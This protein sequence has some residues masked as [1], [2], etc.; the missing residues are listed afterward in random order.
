MPLVEIGAQSAVVEWE[1]PRTSWGD[2]NLEGVW[3]SDN[4]YAVPLE[5][6]PEFADKE[7][8]DG[9]DLEAALAQRAQRIEAVT[10][11][12]AG[13]GAGPGRWCKN[14]QGGSRRS[15]ALIDPR[16]GRLPPLTAAARERIA[17][18]QSARA[19]RGSA[20][21]YTDRSLWDRCVTVGL[22][23]MMFPTGYNNSVKILQTPGYVTITHEMIHGTRIIPLDG[24]PHL[25]ARNLGLASIPKAARFEEVPRR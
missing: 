11:G 25:P 14:L 13:V 5:R 1:R 9:P 3:S 19:A 18:Q 8:P 4:N 10:G 20:D 24:S 21:S 22:P 2:P 16:D 15:S 7:F 6:P 12:A 17:V 23:T